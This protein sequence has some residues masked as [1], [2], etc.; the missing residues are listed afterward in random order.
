MNDE[1]RKEHVRGILRKM[2]P[3]IPLPDQEEIVT[4]TMNSITDFGAMRT[5]TIGKVA[6]GLM[7]IA[8]GLDKE[9]EEQS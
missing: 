7:L 1:Q 6:E 3:D 8:L 4:Q 9:E 5:A 2:F